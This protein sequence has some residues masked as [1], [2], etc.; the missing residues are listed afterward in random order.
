MVG[1]VGG[2]DE[3]AETRKLRTTFG[4][5]ILDLAPGLAELTCLALVVVAAQVVQTHSEP[6]CSLLILV[7]SS[8][9]SCPNCSAHSA[10]VSILTFAELI[11]NHTNCVQ[12]V[13][14]ERALSPKVDFLPIPHLPLE[15]SV[16]TRTQE[17]HRRR[18]RNPISGNHFPENFVTKNH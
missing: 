1:P 16:R 12:D 17:S 6:L 10:R 9:E 2:P 11:S 13:E 7:F 15:A 8:Q 5:R 14:G 3:T 4:T 18:L